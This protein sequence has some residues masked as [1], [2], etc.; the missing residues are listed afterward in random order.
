M[1]HERH[2]ETNHGINVQVVFQSVLLR[3]YPEHTTA[4]AFLLHL[5][6]V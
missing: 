1:T 3:D 6:E 2:A 4:N 5:D